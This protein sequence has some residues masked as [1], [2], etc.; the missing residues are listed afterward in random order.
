[1]NV[2]IDQLKLFKTKHSEDNIEEKWL[3]MQWPVGHIKTSGNCT[4]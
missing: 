1:M 2:K 3:E 4:P